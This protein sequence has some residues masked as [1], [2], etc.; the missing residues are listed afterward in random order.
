M[1]ANRVDVVQHLARA[2][3]AL[4]TAIA[5]FNHLGAVLIDYAETTNVRF[6]KQAPVHVAMSEVVAALGKAA[7]AARQAH[8]MIAALDP[9]PQPQGPGDK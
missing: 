4:Q 2:E 5:R 1:P 7:G 9:D 3:N 8:E 6:I